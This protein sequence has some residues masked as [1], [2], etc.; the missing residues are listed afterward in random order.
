MLLKLGISL[1]VVLVTVLLSGCEKAMH[2]MYDQRK[3]RPLAASDLFSDGQ[4]AR[5]LPPGTIVRSGGAMA[6]PTLPISVSTLP[7][8][9]EVFR[10]RTR[11]RSLKHSYATVRS[12]TTSTVH[13]ATAPWAMATVWSRGVVSRIRPPTT[14]IGC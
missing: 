11:C 2:D 9:T 5:P 4:S 8:S 1:G 10:G 7:T 14:P 3:Y 12:A 13:R 6:G